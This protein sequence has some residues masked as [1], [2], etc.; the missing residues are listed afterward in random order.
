MVLVMQIIYD[1]R[2]V[3]NLILWRVSVTIDAVGLVIGVINH[4]QIVTTNNEYTIADLHN[5]QLLHT[6]LLTVFPLFFPVRFL[7]TDL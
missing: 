7:V 5:L 1:K 3:R 2:I 6:N 4:L